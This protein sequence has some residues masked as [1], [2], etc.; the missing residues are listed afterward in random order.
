MLSVALRLV[1]TPPYTSLLD[2]SVTS[3]SV[4]AVVEATVKVVFAVVLVPSAEVTVAS[5]VYVPAA[6]ALTYTVALLAAADT[7]LDAARPF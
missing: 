4:D 7:G 1:V 3:A 2:V 5:T 6:G